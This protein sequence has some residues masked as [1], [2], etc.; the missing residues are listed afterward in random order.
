MRFDRKTFFDAYKANFDDVLDQSQ[1]DGIEF[2]LTRFEEDSTWKDV[3]HIA[4]AL[5]TVYHETAFTMQPITEYGSKAYF[6]KYDGRKDLGNT[7]PGD[8]YRYRGRGYVQITGR[9]NYTKYGIDETPEKALEPETAF[10][11]LTSGMHRGL[12]TGKKLS[13]FIKGSTKDYK[14]ARKIINGLDKAAALEKYAEKFEKILRSSSSAASAAPS[15][16]KQGTPTVP[17][18]TAINTPPINTP[19]VETTVTRV[20]EGVTVEASKPNQQDVN[21]PAE[22]NSP[23]PYQGIGFWQVIK[24]DLLA[25]TGGNLSLASLTEYAQTASGWPPWLVG[26]IG[27]V[28]L[29]V[30]I[31]TGVYFVVRV[32]HFAVDSWKK[33]RKVAVE[34]EAK[35]AI[36][37]KDIVW[38]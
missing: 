29:G 10:F 6:N 12:F 28:A 31:A 8:G 7:K 32:I 30:L 3:R 23:T 33:S 16:D 9:K 11:I 15:E 21:V 22:V 38:K 14:N 2:L 24:R 20:E 19:P 1:V 37:R 4:Y 34:A 25:A 18:E 27:K 26:M 35:T 36:D 5:S 13:D 17:T